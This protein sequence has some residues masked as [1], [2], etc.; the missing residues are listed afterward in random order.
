MAK[1]LNDGKELLRIA[2][3]KKL[4]IGKA[5][6]TF[7]GGGNQMSK[8]LIE[9]KFKGKINLG[10]A[11]FAF[12]GVQSYHP[13]PAPWLAKKEGALFIDYTDALKREQAIKLITV[14]D[15]DYHPNSRGVK[16]MF[17]TVYPFISEIVRSGK[18]RELHNRR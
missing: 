17:K 15:G 12:P 2:K 6:D 13:N 9:K 18:S 11:I 16:T 14:R 10:N 1:N 8:N 5:P 3:K 7:L 4:Y